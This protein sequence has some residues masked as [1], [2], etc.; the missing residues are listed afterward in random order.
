MVLMIISM[1]LTPLVATLV[2]V[3]PT[4]SFNGVNHV[5]FRHFFLSGEMRFPMFLCCLSMFKFKHIFPN[6]T[7]LMSYSLCVQTLRRTPFTRDGKNNSNNSTNIN[8]SVASII[9]IQQHVLCF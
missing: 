1:C 5:V 8:E 3:S 2:Q 6:R 7:C 4:G 9:N